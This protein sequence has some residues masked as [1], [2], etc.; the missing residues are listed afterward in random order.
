MSED[1]RLERG[2]GL[3]SPRAPDG[4]S[5]VSRTTTGVRSPLRRARSYRYVLQTASNLAVRS[6]S[7]AAEH[8]VRM[9]QRRHTRPTAA[10]IGRLLAEPT[11][12]V[13]SYLTHKIANFTTSCR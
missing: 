3:F 1:D 4:K 8:L 6:A 10:A 13:A 7:N 9:A 2:F 12:V 5:C 11:K